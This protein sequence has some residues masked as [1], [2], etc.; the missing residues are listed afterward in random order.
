MSFDHH[1]RPPKSA[2]Q[3]NTPKHSSY[4]LCPEHQPDSSG[5]HDSVDDSAVKHHEMPPFEVIAAAW[6]RLGDMNES[7]EQCRV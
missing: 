5:H 2:E 3:G 4:P 7:L 6:I 1:I